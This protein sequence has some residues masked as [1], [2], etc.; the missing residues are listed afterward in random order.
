LDGARK[1]IV[2]LP[3]GLAV[4]VGDVIQYDQHHI[5]PS[6]ACQFIPNLAVRKL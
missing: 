6:D 5:D 1:F 4:N 3:S 2:L